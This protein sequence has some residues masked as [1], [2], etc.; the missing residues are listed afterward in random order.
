M[1]RVPP[2]EMKRSS[3][4]WCQICQGRADQ[5]ASFSRQ[6]ESKEVTLGVTARLGFAGIPLCRQQCGVVLIGRSK[7][8]SNSRLWE[9]IFVISTARRAG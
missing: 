4:R 9:T 5:T 6:K 2:E 1:R 3:L 8:L 7:S